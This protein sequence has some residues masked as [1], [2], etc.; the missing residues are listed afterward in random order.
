MNVIDYLKK[1]GNISFTD[2]PFNEVDALVYSQLSYFDFSDTPCC[3]ENLDYS[4]KS[5]L[6]NDYNKKR[7]AAIW[8]AKE[9]HKFAMELKKSSRFYNS[10]V[11]FYRFDICNKTEKQFSACVFS[12]TDSL[13]YIGYRG[14]DASFVGWKEDLNLG[15]LDVIPSQKEALDYFVNFASK[16]DGTYII[17][18]HSKGG[19]LAVYAATFA[20]TELKAKIKMVYSHD[21]P[22]FLPNFYKTQEFENIQSRICKIIPKSAVVGLIMEQYNNYKV[23]NSKAVLLLQ[24]DLLK[25]QIVDDHLDYVSD[26]NKFSKHTRKTMNSWISDMDMETRKVFVNTIYEL[27]V[28]TK[29]ERISQFLKN[30]PK[31]LVT[32]NKKVKDL[33]PQV[34]KCVLQAFNEFFKLYI[35]RN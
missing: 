1:Y 11:G 3:N 17:G 24:H 30:W 10:G 22:G 32:I 6:D 13:Y 7:V 2:K 25:W 33:D 8:N 15:Y 23:V 21:G 12:I 4:L 27:I 34:R 18:G 35:K 20:P 31:N 26:V 28:E 14:T 29:A 16:Y 9:N 19:N 5:F